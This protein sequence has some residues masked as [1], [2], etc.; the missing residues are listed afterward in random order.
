MS[1]RWRQNRITWQGLNEFRHLCDLLVSDETLRVAVLGSDGPDF[2]HGVDLSDSELL[3]AVAKDG[4]K[5]VAEVGAAAVSAWANLPFCTVAVLKGHI[6]GGGACLALASDF[7][8]ATPSATFWFPEI[9]RGMYLSWGIIP[10]LIEELGLPL[11]RRL[12]LLGDA[13][14]ATELPTT[15]CNVSVQLEKDVSALVKRL[16]SK[17]RLALALI[18]KSMVEHCQANGGFGA[19]DVD[20]FMKSINSQAFAAL[21]SA[22][23]ENRSS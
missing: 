4:G 10:R 7:R 18:K 21:M 2:S 16:E 14:P 13:V 11:T 19:R 17:P 8:C 6:I 15:F 1:I 20:R 22:W 5:T 12:A 23:T 9:D 3:A